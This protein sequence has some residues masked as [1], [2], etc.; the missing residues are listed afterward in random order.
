MKKFKSKVIPI[1]CSLALAAPV[2]T[3]TQPASA[4]VVHN[5]DNSYS[6]TDGSSGF[7]VNLVNPKSI[8]FTNNVIDQLQFSVQ[9]YDDKN[10]GTLQSA[11]DVND[12]DVSVT[13]K[14]SDGDV[15]VSSSGGLYTINNLNTGL[16]SSGTY[17]ISITIKN[18][19]VASTSS[20]SSSS[21]TTS[22]SD[23][24]DAS[25]N[26]ESGK[27]DI[28]LNY[29][30]IDTAGAKFVTDYKGGSKISAFSGKVALQFPK[31]SFITDESG[32]TSVDAIAPD[33][34]VAFAADQPTQPASSSYDFQS[35][36]FTISSSDGNSAYQPVLPGTITL[37]Y[38]GD[39]P[40][41]VALYNLSIY[42]K[43]T[44]G[45]W[46]PIGGIVSSSSKTITAPI[47]QFGTYAAALNYK[48]YNIVDSASTWSKPFILAL[49]YKGIINPSDNK[50]YSSTD[51]TTDIKREDFVVMLVKAMG[52]NPVTYTG[53]FADT[54]FSAYANKDYIQAAVNNGLVQGVGTDPTTGNNLFGFG[55]DL[56]REQAAVMISRA[57][58][59][60]TDSYVNL[61]QI[62]N[63]LNKYYSSDLASG[64]STPISDWAIPF[65][66]AVT[67]AK[68]MQGSSNSFSA[69]GNLTFEEASTIVYNIMNKLN[70]FGN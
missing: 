14:G 52:W 65:V 47:S 50:A 15:P 10:G 54:G 7:V 3:L 32:S 68:I 23:N 42:K 27:I 1:L 9:W 8:N 21:T 13:Y 12:N 46:T 34:S 40:R 51:L 49:T 64:S 66:Y 67:N 18:Q 5:V 31:D 70:K 61:T 57:M 55:D 41:D 26:G 16:K 43:N 60:K 59:L 39:V 4:A 45:S 30:N 22:S 2:Y 69:S 19:T 48:T 28:Q 29:F 53:N 62:K 6:F 58:K 44:D 36:A 25:Y 38:N 11:G 24:T 33:Q 17:K 63:Q 20:S 37:A 56:T 35:S